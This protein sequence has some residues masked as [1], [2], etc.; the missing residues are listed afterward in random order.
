V[1]RNNWLLARPAVAKRVIARV[2][3]LI[4]KV[5]FEN[6]RLWMGVADALLKGA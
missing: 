1:Q 3:Q 5:L 2:K 6:Y 4:E